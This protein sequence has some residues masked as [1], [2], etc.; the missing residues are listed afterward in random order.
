MDLSLSVEVSV[1]LIK[2]SSGNP[3]SVLVTRPPSQEGTEVGV[4]ARR[5]RHRT[6]G[7]Q[8]WE[9]AGTAS[10]SPVEH[11]HFKTEIKNVFQA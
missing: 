10:H 1:K 4:W 5:G 9:A 3:I 2:M 8:H 7:G 11:Q 6:Q